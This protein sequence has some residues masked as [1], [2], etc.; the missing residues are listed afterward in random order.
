MLF[1]SCASQTTDEKKG[2]SKTSIIIHSG[3]NQIE[4][5]QNIGGT[6]TVIINDE[7]WINGKKVK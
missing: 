1:S 7:M 5:S 4:V 3:G 2:S 6:D